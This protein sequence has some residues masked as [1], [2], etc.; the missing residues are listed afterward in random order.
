MMTT[1]SV[2]G[3]SDISNRPEFGGVDPREAERVRQHEEYQKA[4]EE[5]ERLQNI[6]R[7]K[8]ILATAVEKFMNKEITKDELKTITD[9]LKL[10]E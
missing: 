6:A 9:A 3:P 7:D 4:L 10:K 1:G 5:Q 8:E 2:Y